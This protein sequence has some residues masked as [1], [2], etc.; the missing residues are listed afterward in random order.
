MNGRPKL[1]DLFCGGGG[2][3]MGY[4]RAGFD[5]T[6]VDIKPQ[7]KYPFTFIQGD[8]MKMLEVGYLRLDDYDAVHGSPPCQLFSSVTPKAAK[9][10]KHVDLLTPL[11]EVFLAW[12]GTWV[13]ENVP[14]APMRQPL[15]LCGSEFGLRTKDGWWLKKHRLFESSVPLMGAGGCWCKGKRILGVHGGGGAP[16]TGDRYALRGVMASAAQGRE[17]MGIDWLNRDQVA[18]A[19][20]PAYTQFIGEQLLTWLGATRTEMAQ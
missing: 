4:H 17:L 10:A 7:P 9:A 3:G 15:V 8:V 12:G 11:R 2:A 5:V 19:V 1:L 18:Q 14:G 13:I 16:G 20:P 6:G